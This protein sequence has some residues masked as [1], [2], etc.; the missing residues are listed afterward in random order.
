MGLNFMR[1]MGAQVK[2]TVRRRKGLRP[3]MSDRAP[4]SGAL[5]NDSSPWGAENQTK[6]KG[7]ENQ[8]NCQQGAE[9]QTNCQQGTENQTN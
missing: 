9:S 2:V 5:R 1:G 7:A 3:Q 4:M 6:A 8:T